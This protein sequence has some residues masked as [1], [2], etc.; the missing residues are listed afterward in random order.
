MS[1]QAVA[2]IQVA[3]P[4]GPEVSARA[5][6]ATVSIHILIG[7]F[8]WRQVHEARKFREEQARPFVIVDFEAGFL[9]CRTGL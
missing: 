7:L 6:C 4:S 5:A 3:E 8:A 9:G 1:Q 2:S